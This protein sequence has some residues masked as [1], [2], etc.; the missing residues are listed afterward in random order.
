MVWV[1]KKHKGVNVPI[2]FKA[3]WIDVSTDINNI[4]KRSRKIYKVTKHFDFE[5]GKWNGKFNLSFLKTEF[6]KENLKIK[7]NHHKLAPIQKAIFRQVVLALRKKTTIKIIA[8]AFHVSTRT[9][10]KIKG[11][12][13]FFCKVNAT[14][15]AYSMSEWFNAYNMKQITDIS[16]NEI[17]NGAEP[18]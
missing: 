5:T 6:R 10:W 12:T 11:K 13:I 16:I 14:R 1:Y 15:L 17:M 7:G 18:D 9:I 8:K 2:R 3:Q 4:T